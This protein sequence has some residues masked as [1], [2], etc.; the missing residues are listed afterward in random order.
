MKN[1]T[2]ATLWIALGVAVFAGLS[3]R[4]LHH[5]YV[6]YYNDDA[7]NIMAAKAISQGHYR[8]LSDP[9]REPIRSL[10]PGYPIF[11]SAFVALVDPRWEA[12]S[13]VSLFVFVLTVAMLWRLLDGWVDPSARDAI[14]L[15]WATHPYGWINSGAVMA[16]PFFLAVTLAFFLLARRALEGDSPTLFQ[17]IGMFVLA[18]FAVATRPHGLLLWGT[19][20]L[21]TAMLR[22]KGGLA[23]WGGMT[24][25]GIVFLAWG[26][27]RSPAAGHTAL[28]VESLSRLGG[29]ASHVI[30]SLARFAATLLGAC[31]VPSLEVRGPVRPWVWVVAIPV[32]GLVGRGVHRRLSEGPVGGRRLAFAVAVF[33]LGVCLLQ[34]LWATVDFR[35]FLP[36]LPWVL[37]FMVEGARGLRF[38]GGKG[39]LLGGMVLCLSGYAG[40][41]A[42]WLMRD[43]SSPAYRPPR[44]TFEWVRQGNDAPYYCLGGEYQFW[45]HTGRRARPVPGG[46]G[47]VDEFR[48]LL[49]RDN[50]RRVFIR[51]LGGKMAFAGDDSYDRFLASFQAMLEGAPALFARV[52]TNPDEWTL[53]YETRSSP[54]FLSAYGEYEE[55]VVEARRGNLGEARKRVHAALRAEPNFPAAGRLLGVLSLMDGRESA[56]A[57]K[58]LN[59]AMAL[60]PRSVPTLLTRARWCRRFGQSSEARDRLADARRLADVDIFAAPYR[61][62][63]QTEMAELEREEN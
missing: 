59:D 51:A 47:D 54:G 46:V 32:A 16:D 43:E 24:A 19:L 36:V 60:A 21:V 33:G 26:L 4:Y 41:H 9:G 44:A 37:F 12:L 56:T 27:G 7:Y 42:R 1:R 50:V 17:G 29:G 13:W 34:G 28:F 55:A 18:L 3:A 11:L 5:R 6:G 61:S 39:F 38:P 45:L 23:L 25:A 40:A 30:H 15:L 22:R 2:R 14:A 49:A 31:V 52:Y 62:A 57:G 48:A 53:V 8:S 10:L 63:V 58:A 20:G 35:Y